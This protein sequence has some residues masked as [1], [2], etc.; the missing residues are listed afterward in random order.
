MLPSPE[1]D[2]T[3][4]IDHTLDDIIGEL[5]EREQIIIRERFLNSKTLAQ[6][7]RQLGVGGHAIQQSEV[8][9]LR[10]LRH[11]AKIKKLLDAD[12]LLGVGRKWTP[13]EEWTQ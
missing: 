9:A 7:G 1:L 11:P 12:P 5:T 8:R 10:K 4:E 3:A 2:I 13:R 6:V